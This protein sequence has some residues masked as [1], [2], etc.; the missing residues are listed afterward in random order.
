MG[1]RSRRAVVA[2]VMAATLLVTACGEAEEAAAPEEPLIRRTFADEAPSNASGD[3]AG[4]SPSTDDAVDPDSPELTPLE[5]PAEP[6]EGEDPPLATGRDWDAVAQ[7]LFDIGRVASQRRD[8]DIARLGMVENCQCFARMEESIEELQAY[9]VRRVTDGEERLVE[10]EFVTEQ[11]GVITLEVVID[12]PT[13]RIVDGAGNEYASRE[14]DRFRQRWT[15]VSGGQ[16]EGPWRIGIARTLE[17][18]EE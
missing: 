10:V 4:A 12:E 8:L 9:D 2:A 13:I 3:A 5:T 15:L 18:G 11:L 7:R 1:R 16:P 6:D 14:P 17:D